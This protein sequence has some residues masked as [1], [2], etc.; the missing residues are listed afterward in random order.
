V[1][2]YST[3]ATACA[4]ANRRLTSSNYHFNEVKPTLSFAMTI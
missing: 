4:A 1:Y 2:E 3:F